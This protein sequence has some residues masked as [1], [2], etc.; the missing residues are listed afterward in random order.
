MLTKPFKNYPN[1]KQK[2]HAQSFDQSFLLTASY[3][4]HARDQK[5]LSMHYA[6]VTSAKS[7]KNVVFKCSKKLIELKPRHLKGCL[8]SV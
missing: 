7:F 5:H 1:I 4:V 3:K 8:L 6:T 2:D